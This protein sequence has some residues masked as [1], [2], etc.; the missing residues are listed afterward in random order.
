MATPATPPPH[1]DPEAHA[2]TDFAPETMIPDGVTTLTDFVVT[3]RQAAADSSITCSRSRE[4]AA[5]AS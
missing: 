5:Q 1:F 4:Q 3:K 2:S